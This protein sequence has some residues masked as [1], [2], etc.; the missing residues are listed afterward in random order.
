MI[1]ARP[2]YNY[3][4]YSGCSLLGGK[5]ISLVSEKKSDESDEFDDIRIS[6]IDG[7][8]RM[9]RQPDAAMTPVVRRLE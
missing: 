7:G 2:E 9:P 8:I 5:D 4:M 3:T 1:L 6:M